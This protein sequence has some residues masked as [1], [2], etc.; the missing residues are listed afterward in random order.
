VTFRRFVYP[1]R[2]YEFMA[3]LPCPLV[4]EH[5][6]S[7]CISADPGNPGQTRTTFGNWCAECLR[8]RGEEHQPRCSRTRAADL[9][10]W[11]R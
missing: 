9:A 1:V 10:G 3:P 4:E 11:P 6:C 5:E 8:M 2:V 7:P